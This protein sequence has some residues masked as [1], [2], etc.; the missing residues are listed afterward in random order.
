MSIKKMNAYTVG[1]VFKD[2]VY[3][4]MLDEGYNFVWPSET[5]YEYDM[6]KPFNPVGELS[7]LLKDEAL[8]EKL[9]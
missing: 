8:A 6:S 5:V 2:G 3:V 1:L 9:Y 7:V 4:R